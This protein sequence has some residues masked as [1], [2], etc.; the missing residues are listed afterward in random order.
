MRKNIWVVFMMLTAFMVNAYADK[1]A[2]NKPFIVASE[3]GAYYV[4]VVP[5]SE[6][7]ANVNITCYTVKAG[8]DES[9]WSTK[10]EIYTHDMHLSR[11]GKFLAVV[12]GWG[13]GKVPQKTD[14]ALL[15]YDSGKLLKE[16]NIMELIKDGKVLATA[17]HYVWKKGNATLV[18][19]DFFETRLELKTVNAEYL[20]DLRT[21]KIVK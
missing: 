12:A 11:D 10:G 21:G 20:F 7:G 3:N 19:D 9:V 15:I 2:A 4:K 5:S 13:N 1:M 16:Y 6:Y 14:K 17:S 18:A 8:Q